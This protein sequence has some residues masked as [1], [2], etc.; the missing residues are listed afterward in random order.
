M[1]TNFSGAARINALVGNEADGKDYEGHR[2]QL[3]LVRDEIGE[4]LD[5]LPAIATDR[6][7][8]RDDVQDV[9]FTAYGLA[10]RL[11]MDYEQ[12]VQLALGSVVSNFTN[13][14]ITN[15][16]TANDFS[17]GGILEQMVNAHHRLS[18]THTLY[19]SG[20]ADL[21]ALGAELK[22]LLV[23]TYM[24]A[25][26]MGYPADE[27]F[28]EV[29][30]S[31]MTKFDTNVDEAMLTSDK[32][33][34]LGVDTYIVPAVYN[35]GDVSF[36]VIVTKSSKDQ[37]GNDGKE[38][39]ED[40]WL[41]SINF[42]EPMYKPLPTINF[43]PS[44]TQHKSHVKVNVS[45]DNESGK[46]Y[47]TAV[48]AKALASVGMTVDILDQDGPSGGRDALSRLNEM[49]EDR[50]WERPKVTITQSTDKA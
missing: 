5:N 34:A 16:A 11:G 40:K 49:T 42:Q 14:V 31:N 12:H 32:Y 33:K 22:S 29:V 39:P 3:K 19:C 30:R 4:G 20:N 18:T 37:V 28:T 36:N 27:D 13:T 7:A 9:L 48:L 6:E 47:I 38:Y 26:R 15:S 25:I 23:W 46:S 50:N 1:I 41:K 17:P 45:G 44:N 35:L 43:E 21:S 8:L 2:R 10:H 24:L